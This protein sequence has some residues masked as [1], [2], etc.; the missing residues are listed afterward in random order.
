MLGTFEKL[1]I[2]LDPHYVQEQESFST[3]FCRNPQG[4]E[5]TELANGVSVSFYIP[6]LEEFEIWVEEL[7]YANRVSSPFNCFELRVKNER[8]WFEGRR[9]S[10]D[11]FQML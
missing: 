10:S 1:G 3:F 4:I 2:I 7:I 6:S 8:D 11:D 5:F 9:K